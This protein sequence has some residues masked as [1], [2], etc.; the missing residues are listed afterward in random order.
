MLLPQAAYTAPR[1]AHNPS[2]GVTITGMV[3]IDN[4]IPITKTSCF[5]H[6]DSKGTKGVGY[7]KTFVTFVPLCEIELGCGL[8][9]RPR[10]DRL[11]AGGGRSCVSGFHC[12][13]IG[14]AIG[15]GIGIAAI[16][17]LVV[18]SHCVG[19]TVDFE[20]DSDTDIDL[21]NVNV[22]HTPCTHSF[23]YPYT[24][25]LPPCHQPI[26]P[27]ITKNSCSVLP[28]RLTIHP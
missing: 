14:I 19:A 8:G 2:A 26:T 20:P 1:R 21:E 6:E 3:W 11:V 7:G 25:T 24:I 15:I 16:I 4:L 10:C 22:G 9:L 28:F 13:T 17:T 12:A 27:A 5:S 23:T 18:A